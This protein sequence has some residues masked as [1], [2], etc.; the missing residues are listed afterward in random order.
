MAGPRWCCLQL[1]SP[2]RPGVQTAPRRRSG[3]RCW[4]QSATG[5][6]ATSSGHKRGKI[7]RPAGGVE[8]HIPAARR[9][10]RSP[11]LT[12][13]SSTRIPEKPR[14]E[15]AWSTE[16]KRRR[17][18][19]RTVPK[20]RLVQIPVGQTFRLT[21][22]GRN[23]APAGLSTCSGP[24]SSRTERRTQ[25]CQNRRAAGSGRRTRECSACCA[26]PSQR[27]CQEDSHLRPCVLSFRFFHLPQFPVGIM[28]RTLASSST[29]LYTA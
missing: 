10:Q 27:P 23:R 13:D 9:N 1:S 16:K 5:E 14:G 29:H 28:P 12:D 3:T 21:P 25:P 20:A 11:L 18:R 8:S 24:E 17:N 19:P 6:T 2:A 4:Q 15:T 22:A 7:H 26:P